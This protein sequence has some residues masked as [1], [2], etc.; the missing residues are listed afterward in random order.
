MEPFGL[1]HVGPEVEDLQRRLGTSATR[2]PT[3]SGS[4][5]RATRAAV[6]AFQQERGLAA[7]GIVGDDTWRP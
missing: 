5:D 4:S 2:A 7:D 3:T 6:R 1:G